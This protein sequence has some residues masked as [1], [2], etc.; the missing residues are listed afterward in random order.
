SFD[1]SV[2][3]TTCPRRLFDSLCIKRPART[4]Y[5]IRCASNDPPA[6]T[7]RIIDASDGPS[8]PTVRI[9]VNQ[10]TCPR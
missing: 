6:P 4:D 1:S 10:T 9:I 8:A 7:V 2:N 5:S 3:Q